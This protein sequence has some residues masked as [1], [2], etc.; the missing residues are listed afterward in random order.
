MHCAICKEECDKNITL[1]ECGH[2]FHQECIITWF[3][4]G[5]KSCP[6]CRDIGTFNDKLFLSPIGSKERYGEI[7]ALCKHHSIP[8]EFEKTVDEIAILE[9]DIKSTHRK[10]KRYKKN[11]NVKE[12]LETV[13]IYKRDIKKKNISKIV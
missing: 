1:P 11:V 4:V 5:N 2:A 3:R 13:C 10:L 12:I 6:V 7:I 8:E 9:G